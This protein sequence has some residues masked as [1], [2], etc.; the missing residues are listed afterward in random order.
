L[1]G[2]RVGAGSLKPGTGTGKPTDWLVY[3]TYLKV[4]FAILNNPQNNEIK[5][6]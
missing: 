5:N 2:A 3:I 4:S 1:D 6:L